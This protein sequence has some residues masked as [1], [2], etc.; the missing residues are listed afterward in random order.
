M[1]VSRVNL[2]FCSLNVHVVLLAKGN[3]SSTKVLL[4]EAPLPVRIRATGPKSYHVGRTLIFVPPE[5]YKRS[6]KDSLLQKTQS[7]EQGIIL[8]KNYTAQYHSHTRD[9][10]A[11]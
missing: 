2:I 10:I 6:E 1:L 5:E 8:Q 7:F 4:D 11:E 9:V 3:L